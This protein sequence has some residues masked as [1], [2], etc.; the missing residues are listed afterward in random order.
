MVSLHPVDDQTIC[1]KTAHVCRAAFPKGSL[2]V[3]LRDELGPLFEDAQ[4]IGVFSRRGRSALSPGRLALV[5]VLQF[6]EG[7][8]DRQ[9]ADAVRGRVDWKY[10]LGLDL[11]DAGFDFSALSEFRAWL[12]QADADRLLDLMP[13]RLR[14]V[15][16]VKA[17]GRQRTDPTHVLAAIRTVNRL[18]LVGETMRAA[19]GA[20]AAAAPDWPAPLIEQQ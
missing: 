19:L 4:F 12:V 8:S 11:T 16:L 6:V 13:Q 2:P 5:S 14:E 7:L 9:A 20:L 1:E 15:G 17:G 3:R 18:E 10:A